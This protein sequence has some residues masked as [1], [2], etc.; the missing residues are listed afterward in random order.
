MISALINIWFFVVLTL[1]AGVLVWAFSVLLV[2]SPLG[3]AMAAVV[4]T[5]LVAGPV[6]MFIEE[7]KR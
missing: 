4:L 1:G 2:I 6:L 3:V 5:I 7:R